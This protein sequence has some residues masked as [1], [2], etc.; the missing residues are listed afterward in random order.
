MLYCQQVD[1]KIHHNWDHTIALV[2]KML[3]LEAQTTESESFGESEHFN[4]GNLG[5]ISKHKISKEW[6]RFAS[7]IVNKTMPWLAELLDQL[8]ELKPDEGCISCLV[9]DG[10]EHIDM[11]DMQSAL[12]FIFYNSDPT[13]TTWVKDSEH[14]ESYPSDINTAWIL[15]TQKPHGINNSGERWSLSIHFNTDYHIVKEWFN[16]NP[17]LEFGEKNT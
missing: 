5:T 17:K 14:S 3:E 7:P 9:G 8:K 12:N 4:L 6:Y 10:S 11:P 15:D 1:L 2:T 13:A 16:N